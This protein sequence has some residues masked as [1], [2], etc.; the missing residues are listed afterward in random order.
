[1]PEGY[2]DFLNRI[3]EVGR[4]LDAEFVPVWRRLIILNG[5]TI[6]CDTGNVVDPRN[7]K[8]LKKAEK[9]DAWR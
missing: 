5:W 2:S 1:M 7:G 3:R 4:I 9:K 6:D 8:I